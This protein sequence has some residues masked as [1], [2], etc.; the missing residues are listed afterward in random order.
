[1]AYFSRFI[2]KSTFLTLACPNWSPQASGPVCTR[3]VSYSLG[4]LAAPGNCCLR[5]SGH[6]DQFGHRLFHQEQNSSNVQSFLSIVSMLSPLTASSFHY[7]N[8]TH[9]CLFSPIQGVNSSRRQFLPLLPVPHN[10]Q[11]VRLGGLSL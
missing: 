3:L 8:L 1:M 11:A 5:L 9:L 7:F 10:A 2:S 6:S 4:L